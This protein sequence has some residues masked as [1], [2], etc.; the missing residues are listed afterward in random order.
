MNAK[1]TR[2]W[3]NLISVVCRARVF[4]T[5]FTRFR[6]NTSPQFQPE[7]GQ[8]IPS[9]EPGQIAQSLEPGQITRSSEP[10]QIIASPEPGQITQSLEPG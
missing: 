9:P 2:G 3:L 8:I 6:N 1:K 4:T 7:P 5:H 10:G